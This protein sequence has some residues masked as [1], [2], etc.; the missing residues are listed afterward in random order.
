MSSSKG[1]SRPRNRTPMSLMSPTLAGEFFAT[2]PTWEAH[3]YMYIYVNN[4]LV[5]DI[6]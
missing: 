6:W 3:I 5:K 1:A 2:S 4:A